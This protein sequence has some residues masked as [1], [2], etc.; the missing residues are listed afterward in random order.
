MVT[1]DK[2]KVRGARQLMK[3]EDIDVDRRRRKIL[4]SVIL[5]TEMYDVIAINR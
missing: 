3:I 1:S 2:T 4:F 5:E